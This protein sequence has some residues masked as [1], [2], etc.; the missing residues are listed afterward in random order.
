MPIIIGII[1]SYL[2]GSIPTAYLF[3]KA[4]KGID[5]RKHGSGNVGATNAMRILGRGPGITV[6]FIDVVKGFVAV[7]VVGAMLS[8]RISYISKDLVVLACGFSCIIGHNWTIFLGFK[9]GK[10][11]ATTLGVLLG[12]MAGNLVLSVAVGFVFLTWVVMFLIVRIVS[13][14]SLAAAISLP[15]YLL[16][17]DQP[18]VLLCAGFVL[19]GFII[20]RHK[21]NII[22]LIRKEEPHICLKF[23]KHQENAFQK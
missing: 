22:R 10:G 15:V 18:K 8:S 2:L 4:L 6:L 14:A 11:V 1:I 19:S 13:F 12:L 17:F 3:G 20:L 7:A 23:P 21:K 9:G 16:I 5:I